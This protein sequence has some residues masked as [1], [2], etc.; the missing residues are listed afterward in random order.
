MKVLVLDDDHW[1]AD[2]GAAILNGDGHRAIPV[3]C[4][5]D[6]LEH[7]RMIQFDVALVGVVIPGMSGVQVG[8]RI[9]ELAPR[10]QVILWVEEVPAVDAQYCESMGHRFEHIRAPFRSEDLLSKIREVCNW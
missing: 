6:A 7:A 9:R 5:S 1:I 8:I 2:L 10:C 4:V 3:Y